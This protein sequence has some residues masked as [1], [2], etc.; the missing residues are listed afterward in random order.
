[1]LH[2]DYYVSHFEIDLDDTVSEELS[3]NKTCQKEDFKVCY[4]KYYKILN[5]FLFSNKLLVF[6]TGIHN[7]HV[8]IASSLIWVCTACLGCFG[9]QLLFEIL[10]YLPHR[11]TSFP[12]DIHT[13]LNFLA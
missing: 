5:T 9:R 11:H 1:M 3:G 7:M 8:R 6:R 4:G 12:L 2:R 13:P 10:E